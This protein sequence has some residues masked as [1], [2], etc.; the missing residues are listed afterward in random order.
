MLHHEVVSL[1][2]GPIPSHVL[3]VLSNA[4][5]V[6]TERC[7]DS[8]SVMPR[9]ARDEIPLEVSTCLLAFLNDGRDKGLMCRT[10]Y[11]TVGGV[12]MSSLVAGTTMSKGTRPRGGEGRESAGVVGFCCRQGAEGA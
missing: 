4:T 11:C 9:G 2:H 6:G 8:E 12:G 7:R 10:V 1:E 3:D 5:T